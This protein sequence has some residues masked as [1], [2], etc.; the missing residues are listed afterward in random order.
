MLNNFE[1]IKSKRVLVELKL[2][3]SMRIHNI[4]YLN[5]L[6]KNFID[7][8]IDQGNKSISLVIINNEKE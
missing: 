2:L 8:L 4:F 7:L 3:Q 5:L 6:Y 1:V